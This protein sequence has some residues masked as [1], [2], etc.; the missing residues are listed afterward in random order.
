ML[1]FENVSKKYGNKQVL[2]D[3]D[4]FVDDGEFVFL[5]G[6]SG[7]G[8]TTLLRMILREES[9]DSGKVFFDKKDLLQYS[10]SELPG[11][12]R[13]IGF[14][15]QDFKLLESK[16]ASQNVS[17]SLDILGKSAKQIKQLVPELLKSVGLSEKGNNYPWQLSGGEKQRLAIARAVALEPKLIIADEPTGNLDKGTSWEIINLLNTLNK[18]NGTTIIVATHDETLVNS[19]KKKV[20][21]IE[22]G[23]IQNA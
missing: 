20:Y 18:E 5:M 2:D 17:L 8:K 11:I 22:N 13:K 7:A 3:V 1:K 12:R 6:T 21:K 4:L 15:F 16:N 9:P 10:K 19:L 14:I 23:R